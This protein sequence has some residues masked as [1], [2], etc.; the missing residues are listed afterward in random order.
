MSKITRVTAL[1]VLLSPFAA[2]ATDGLLTGDSYISS[3]NPTSNFGAQATMFAGSGATSV[4]Q[5]SLST[6]PAGT[7]HRLQPISSVPSSRPIR[8]LSDRNPGGASRGSSSGSLTF[9]MGEA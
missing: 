1:C 8:A 9:A 4:M 7:S 2:F 3:G 6:L 5:F